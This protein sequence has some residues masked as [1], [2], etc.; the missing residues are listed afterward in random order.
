MW[1]QDMTPFSR[2]RLEKERGN[3]AKNEGVKEKKVEGEEGKDLKIS[4]GLQCKQMQLFS[5]IYTIMTQQT[6]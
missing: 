4:C 2:L 1:Y 3:Q 6:G 5:C